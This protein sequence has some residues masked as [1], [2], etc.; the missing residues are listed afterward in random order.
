MNNAYD[1]L[2]V[3]ERTAVISECHNRLEALATK[4]LRALTVSKTV[5]S[6]NSFDNAIVIQTP[7]GDVAT[8]SVMPTSAYVGNNNQVNYIVFDILVREIKRHDVCLNLVNL[9]RHRC[10]DYP[11]PKGRNDVNF[12]RYHNKRWQLNL[13][14]DKSKSIDHG[15]CGLLDLI[16]HICCCIQQTNANRSDQVVSGNAQ[17][18]VDTNTFTTIVKLEQLPPE[19]LAQINDDRIKVHEAEA[20]SV[21]NY[22]AVNMITAELFWEVDVGDIHRFVVI[23]RN[24]KMK[25]D[26]MEVTYDPEISIRLNDH[27]YIF[28][29]AGAQISFDLV[30][31][32]YYYI[33]YSY[34]YFKYNSVEEFIKKGLFTEITKNLKKLD[35]LKQHLANFRVP[36]E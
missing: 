9:R 6:D 3:A 36:V 1:N 19:I 31:N 26:T 18:K 15:K 33:K 23:K 34:E 25:T 29:S 24:A 2:S 12:F 27:S 32:V 13:V 7:Y 11:D 10:F 17:Q 8:L 21:C 28:N 35:A 20:S 14:Y 5:T 22:S 30:E 4:Q 16:Y